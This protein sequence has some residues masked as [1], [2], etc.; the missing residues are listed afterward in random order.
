MIQHDPHIFKGRF[1]Y[2]PPGYDCKISALSKREEKGAASAPPKVSTPKSHQDRP[3]LPPDVWD[4]PAGKLKPCHVYV[5]RCNTWLCISRLEEIL[6]GCKTLAA[7]LLGQDQTFQEAGISSEMVFA[8]VLLTFDFEVKSPESN[9][10][11]ALNGQLR[12][13]DPNFLDPCRG[14]LHYLMTG[15][16]RMPQLQGETLFVE[17]DSFTGYPGH[18]GTWPDFKFATPKESFMMP[19]NARL[20]LKVQV[21]KDESRSRNIHHIL[22]GKCILLPNFRFQVGLSKKRRCPC[23]FS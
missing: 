17:D 13:P 20:I 11:A 3:V 1:E 7:R 6:K 12:R 9:F 15:L 23:I 16:S 8:M 2:H 21:A 10:F 5:R 18:V 22:S 14:Y 4:A 19:A